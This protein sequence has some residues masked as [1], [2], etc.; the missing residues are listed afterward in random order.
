MMVWSKGLG[1]LTLPMELDK[2]SVRVGRDHL[3]MEGMIEPVFW[4]Y[5]LKVY[6]GDLADCMKIL[7]DRRTV[8]SLAARPGIL[9]PFVLRLAAFIPKVSVRM[10][11]ARTWG[12]LRGRN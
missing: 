6:P 3:A 10:L 12:R 9:L 8:M 7:A 4:Q 2:A 5:T 1:R 11:I